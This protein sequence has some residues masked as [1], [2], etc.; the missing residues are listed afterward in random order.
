MKEHLDIFLPKVDEEWAETLKEQVLS[1]TL[2]LNV[3]STEAV[4]SSEALRQ[5][6][7]QTQAPY[8][9]LVVKD[10]AIQLGEAALE[11]MVKV[12]QEKHIQC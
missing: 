9:A 3:F 6:A 2:V 10:T 11:R 7:A 8:V 12:A 1:G 4:R 5:I